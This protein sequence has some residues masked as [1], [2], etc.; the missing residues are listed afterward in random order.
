MNT[1]KSS[2]Q[3]SKEF[4]PTSFIQV[5]NSKTRYADQGHG[6]TILL[7]HGFPENLQTWRYYFPELSKHYRVIACDLKGFGY[8]DKPKGDYTPLG[9]A[10]FVN[11]F[12]ETLPITQ[13]HCVGSDIGL[14]I[15][16]AFAL[17]YPEK[18]NKLILMALSL[19][20]LALCL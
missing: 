19:P 9:M 20:C 11:D 3:Q 16:T 15:A 14:T 2:L 12:L 1:K 18:V 8:S 13:V 5:G 7:L 10:K 17:N 6:D 4:L